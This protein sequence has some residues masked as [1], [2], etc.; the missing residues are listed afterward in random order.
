MATNMKQISRSIFNKSSDFCINLMVRI[1]AALVILISLIRFT[2]ATAQPYV[3][4]LTVRYTYAFKN[5]QP[6]ATPF[7]HLFIGSDIPVKFKNGT[8]FFRK[9]ILRELEH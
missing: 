4:P 1:P 7:T 6:R 8:I 3:D 5:N 2:N 9:P